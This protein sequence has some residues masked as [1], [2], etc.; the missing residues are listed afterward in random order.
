M[1]IPNIVLVTI[2]C[3]RY[4]RCGFNGHD[5]DT[6]PVLD[7]LAREAT[8][9]DSAVAPGPRTSESIP[10]ILSGLRSSECAYFDQLAYKSIPL[11]TPTLATWLSEQGYRTVAEI[12]N[13]Q[14]SP[15]RNFDR[16]FDK[17]E[18]LRIETKGDQFRQDIES[19]D[20]S[21][22][23][24][25]IMNF[26]SRVRD[27]IRERMKRN[28]SSL[29]GPATLAFIFDRVVRKRSGW[30]TIAGRSVVDQLLSTLQT[31]TDDIP[32]FVWTH[33]NDLHAPI[34]P[35]RVREGG[36]L[37][38]PSDMKQFCWD[39]HRV[40]NQYEPNYA[41]MYDSTLR[42]V[43]AQ[44]GRL[45]EYFR[46]N[47]MWN[48][49]IMIVTADHGEA[50]HDRGM[51]GHAAGN[52][53]YS[54]DPTRDYM[55][56]ELLH[57]PL[58]I[59]EPNKTSQR[60]YSPFSLLYLHELIAEIAN[61]EPGR[62]RRTSERQSHCK[63][64][65]DSIIMADAMSSDGHT[66]AVRQGSLKWISE[67]IGGERGSIDG[68]PLLFNL[69]VDPGERTNLQAIQSA[70]ALAAAATDAFMSPD[71]LTPVTGR[72]DAETRELLNQLGYT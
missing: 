65:T 61:L 33:L 56:E 66:I 21:R 40:A 1:T 17:F 15:L 45:V 9:F 2:D 55:Y 13:P 72:I 42:Y 64:S 43:D 39:S 14:L 70:P 7:Q 35:D 24:E 26:R 30:P 57:I 29:L 62:F 68:D 67:C 48:N 54:Y 27:P 18:N 59:R 58:L 49:T 10:G 32:L 38:S 19:D 20:S 12:S 41:A 47:N 31:I 25:Q 4:D 60:V 37:N 51:Y 46:D 52:D 28:S 16:G 11:N 50:L 5:Q 23:A 44:I 3:L 22:I 34:H 69:E 36:L 53:R 6:T 8:I 63:P 71:T